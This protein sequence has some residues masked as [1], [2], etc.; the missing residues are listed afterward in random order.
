VEPAQQAVEYADLGKYVNKRIIVRS[1]LNT[2]R[3]GV[4]T[5][6]SASEIDLK[7]DSGADLSMP[8]TSIKSIG[9]PIGPADPLFPK[10]ESKAPD[11]K[12]SDV[13][14]A[15]AKPADVKPLVAKPL[16][17]KPA[18]AKGSADKSAGGKADAKPSGAKP[19]DTKSG[20]GKT[21]DGSAKKN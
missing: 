11:A 13:K 6:F 12:A 8:A 10:V 4:L 15:D 21:G 1:K 17:N 18:D 2:T 16:D 20:D 19:S 9:I 3:A 14:P 7:L 5:R